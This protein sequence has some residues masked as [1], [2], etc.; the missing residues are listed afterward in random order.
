MEEAGV[1]LGIG[2]A[3]GCDDVYITEEAGTVEGERELP[4]FFMRDW[5]AGRRDANKYLVNPWNEDGS[6]V[7][8]E[9]YPKLRR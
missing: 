2:V 3:T 7:D 1:R 8:L 6:L 4:L 5:R 9:D